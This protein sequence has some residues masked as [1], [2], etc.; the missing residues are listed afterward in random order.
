MSKLSV[1]TMF[2]VFLIYS[3]TLAGDLV[4]TPVNPSFGGSSFN[5]AHLLGIAEINRPDPPSAAASSLFG[6]SSS[7]ADL[8]T[9]QLESRILSQLSFDIVEQIFDG[10]AETGTFEFGE[11]SL[12]FERLLDG[13]VRLAITDAAS[14]ST[15]DIL[16]PSFIS[17]G[18]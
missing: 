11:T 15:T 9:R 5:S 18:G 12:S 6:S 14:G 10:S 17:D 16:I 13:S 1:M 4:Y 2:F 8:F 3:K 7:Q